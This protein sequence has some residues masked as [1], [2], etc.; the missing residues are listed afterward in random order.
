MGQPTYLKS[1]GRGENR[2]SVKRGLSV[3]ASGKAPQ[4]PRDMVKAKL[5]EPQLSK[6]T[7]WNPSESVCDRRQGV[8]SGGTLRR[9]PP[10]RG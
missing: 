7:C 3:D 2:M 8:T 9:L 6:G 4:D 5:P 10:H 1:K